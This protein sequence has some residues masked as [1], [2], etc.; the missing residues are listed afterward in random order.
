VRIYLHLKAREPALVWFVPPWW[1]DYI[2][3][4]ALPGDWPDDLDL[5]TAPTLVR[6]LAAQARW[7]EQERIVL[8]PRL[9]EALERAAG[10]P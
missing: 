3:V 5:T 7:L 1:S 6:T 2:S 10:E 4:A 9:A 8:D